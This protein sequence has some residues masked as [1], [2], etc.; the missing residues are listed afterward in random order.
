MEIDVEKKLVG[1]DKKKVYEACG[2]K[3]KSIIYF[4][5]SMCGK[6]FHKKSFFENSHNCF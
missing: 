5:C 4:A 3:N 2:K 6:H 1:A